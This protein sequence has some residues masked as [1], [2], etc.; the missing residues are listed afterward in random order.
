MD[1]RVGNADTNLVRP[2]WLRRAFF[3]PKQFR[4]LSELVMDDP[5]H[6]TL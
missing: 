3:N 2:E 6:A 5:S 1:R 4:R